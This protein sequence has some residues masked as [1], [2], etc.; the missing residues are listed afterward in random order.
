M[1]EPNTARGEIKLDVGDRSYVVAPT[2]RALSVLEERTGLGVI[3]LWSKIEKL[4]ITTT[5]QV[6][7]CAITNGGEKNK[8]SYDDVCNTVA[9]YGVTALAPEAAKF[10]GISVGGLFNASEDDVDEKDSGG[11]AVN[12]KSED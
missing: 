2:F 8:P 6:L 4:S 7:Y 12:P 3:E 9:N 10:L 11:K 5:A 1:A